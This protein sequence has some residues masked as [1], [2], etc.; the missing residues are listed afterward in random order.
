MEGFNFQGL[1]LVLAGVSLGMIGAAMAGAAF[2]PE[3]AERYKRQ[4][5][6]V[7]TGVVLV[8]LASVIISALGG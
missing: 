3:M 2:W 7:I 1:A 8:A 5:M 6:T 4:I